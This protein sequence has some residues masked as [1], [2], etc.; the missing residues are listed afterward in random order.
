RLPELLRIA[1]AWGVPLHV[2]GKGEGVGALYRAMADPRM[3]RDVWERLDPR[4]RAMTAALADA[5]AGHAAPTLSELA[6]LLGV[7]EA[8]ARETALRLYRAGILAREGDD[9]PLPIGA[10][11]RLILPRELALNVRRIQDELAAGDV[12]Q[13]PLRVLVE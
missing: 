13:R 6:A 2:E 4:A 12:A 11:P 3:M 7:P 8:D 10:P 9:E 5:G 1:D